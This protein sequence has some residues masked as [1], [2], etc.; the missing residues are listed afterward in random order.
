MRVKICG[1]TGADD[2]RVAVDAGADALGFNFHE[3]SPRHVT[4]GQA[5]RIVEGLPPFVTTVALFVDP[6]PGQVRQVLD[7][8]RFDLLQFHGAESPDLCGSFG[9]PYLKACAVGDG[10]DIEA[11][12]TRY[13]DA[14]GLLLDACVEGRTGGTGATFDWAL[15]PRGYP[16]PLILA[17]GLTPDNVV[18][19]IRATRPFAVDVSSGVELSP[20]RKDPRRVRRFIEEVHR[21]EDFA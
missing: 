21:V 5:A 4:A 6:S 20:G 16:R 17:G 13:S 1:I 2:A 11:L 10:F 12:A 9:A 7:E 8:V 19:A 3:A 14:R 15:W 18:A